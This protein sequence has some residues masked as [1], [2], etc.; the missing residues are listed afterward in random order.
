MY[1]LPLT[2]LPGIQL[3][4]SMLDYRDECKDS[5]LPKF[6]VPCTCLWRSHGESVGGGGCRV[7]REKQRCND[8]VWAAVGVAGGESRVWAPAR[9]GAARKGREVK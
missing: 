8:V 6:C 7:G 4:I 5:E 9:R 1:Q 3:D 2:L